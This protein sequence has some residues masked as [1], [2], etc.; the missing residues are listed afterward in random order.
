MLSNSDDCSFLNQIWCEPYQKDYL[1]MLYD[2]CRGA[3]KVE[4]KQAVVFFK[5]S[6]ITVVSALLLT[7][8]RPNSKRFGI[9]QMLEASLTLIK[10]NLRFSFLTSHLF[11][12]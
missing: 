2:K 12:S 5:L 9:C 7:I 10:M 4:G 6:G 11:N 8:G 1:T 3:G